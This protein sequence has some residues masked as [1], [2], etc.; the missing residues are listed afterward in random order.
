M[1]SPYSNKCE[2]QWYE[3]TNELVKE[4][5]L[6]NQ[7]V[8]M[9]FRTWNSILN[10]KINSFLNLRIKDMNLSPQAVSN[11]FHD[12]LPEYIERNVT[13]WKKGNETSEKDI[14]YTLDNRYSF[15]I[16]ISSSKNSIF[17]NRSYG[18]VVNSPKKSK[19]GY[20]LAIN[21]DKLT[22]DNP[23]IRIIRFGWLDHSDWISQSSATGQ[24]ARLG[25]NTMK[26]KFQTLYE[27]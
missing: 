8:D 1:E 23:Q 6:T 17:G 19:D 2:S 16:K 3:I 18:Q 25:K 7:L 21:I 26:L 24:Q 22:T 5:P 9:C 11:L 4:H 27:L 10:G 12:I 14:V 15:E 20:Y 13:N